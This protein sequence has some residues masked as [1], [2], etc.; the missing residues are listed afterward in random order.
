MANDKDDALTTVQG[1][2]GGKALNDRLRW[3]MDN[4]HLVAPATSCGSLP[5][6]CEV[7]LSGFMIDT[8]DKHG[9]IYAV[10]GGKFGLSRV[11]L[12]KIGTALGISWDPK[13]S[14]RQDDGSDPNYCAWTAVGHYRHFDGSVQTVIGSKEMDLRKGS[15]QLQALQA[16][17][18]E[19]GK[20]ADGQIREMR[21]HIVAHAES[22]ARLRAIANMGVKRS[23]TMEELKKPFVIAKLMFTGRT[24]NPELQKVFANKIA[25]SFLGGRAAAYGGGD[26]E[27]ALGAAPAHAALPG[28]APPPPVGSVGADEDDP[29][30]GEPVG[31][32]G[33]AKQ[34]DFTPPATTSGSRGR[35]TSSG[36]GGGGGRSVHTMKFGKKKGV[37]IT[38]SAVSLD[39]LTWYASAIE[40]SIG[41]PSKA[42]WKAD[43]EADLKLVRTEIE[44]RHSGGVVGDDSQAPGD[45]DSD[46]PFGG[47]PNND[48]R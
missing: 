2:F 13:L 19:P 40:K 10:G 12:D 27:H 35:A 1:T 24:D 3:A 20:T 4:M 23:Y 7:A 38:D 42:R 30:F 9:E 33:G 11:A 16:K 45:D 22:K 18:R 6:G 14:G 21:L 32:A 39:E 28:R 5:L 25:D 8:E 15:P 31:N 36:G 44:T 47:D 26:G 46:I 43:N 37:D 34:G 48:G 29:A 41:D 17:I